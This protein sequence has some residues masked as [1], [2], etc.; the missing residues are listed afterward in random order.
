MQ[1]KSFKKHKHPL[2]SRQTCD[3]KKS[4]R[5]TLNLHK[6]DKP[7]WIRTHTQAQRRTH[8]RKGNICFFFAL[9]ACEHKFHS[10]CEHLCSLFK[11]EMSTLNMYDGYNNVRCLRWGWVILKTLSNSLNKHLHKMHQM[12]EMVLDKVLNAYGALFVCIIFFLFTFC[13]S[14]SVH[15]S[16][17]VIFFFYSLASC[18]LLAVCNDLSIVLCAFVSFGC[19]TQEEKEQE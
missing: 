10:L 18:L 3:P 16:F 7:N 11:H 15:I 9:F 8:I 4:E 13:M 12:P 19:F 17:V 2:Y 6:K 1:S 14:V 5:I